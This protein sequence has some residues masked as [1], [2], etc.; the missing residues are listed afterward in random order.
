MPPDLELRLTLTSLNY[1]S[2]QT[3][4]FMVPK[5]IKPLKFYCNFKNEKVWVLTVFK[6]FLLSICKLLCGYLCENR[7]YG[8]GVT[9]QMFEK[10]R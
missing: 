10:A 7:Y 4:F 8:A 9:E 6:L 5:V 1:P 2:S 3:Y